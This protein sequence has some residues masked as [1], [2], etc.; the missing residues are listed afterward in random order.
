VP[1]E[2]LPQSPETDGAAASRWRPRFTEP[3]LVVAAF[4]AWGALL[5]GLRHRPGELALLLLAVPLLAC[6][7]RGL[8]RVVGRA[9]GAAG[10]VGMGIVGFG[11]LALCTGESPATL[12]GFMLGL[13]KPVGWT[14]DHLLLRVVPLIMLVAH[15]WRP[16]WPTAFVS[17]L[18]VTGFLGVTLL[19][20]HAA[21]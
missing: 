11:T 7:G 15:P 17:A 4:V 20:L 10:I 14:G 18:G 12:A 9:W 2:D 8:E 16:S 13:L 3:A 1:P 6:I 19:I 5:Q 21:G